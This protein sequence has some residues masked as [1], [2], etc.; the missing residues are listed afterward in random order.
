MQQENK[1]VSD[2]DQE[3]RQPPTTDQP[4]A[5]PVRAKEH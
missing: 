2:F 5:W 3:M 4:M 1:K